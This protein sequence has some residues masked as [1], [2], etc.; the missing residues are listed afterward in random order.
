MLGKNIIFGL[1]FKKYN[2]ELHLLW[3]LTVKI[4]NSGTVMSD[5]ESQVVSYAKEPKVDEG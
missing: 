2:T 1:I 5:N 3:L 4:R